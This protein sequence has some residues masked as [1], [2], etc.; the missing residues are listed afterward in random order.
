MV[1]RLRCNRFLPPPPP[2]PMGG[3]AGVSAAPPHGP[4]IKAGSDLSM[5]DAGE[6]SER[7]DDDLPV[8]PAQAPVPDM[9]ITVNS[10][11]TKLVPVIC[12]M[13]I[14]QLPPGYEDT[15]HRD[16]QYL[17][18][19]CMSFTVPAHAVLQSCLTSVADALV[20]HARASLQLHAPVAGPGGSGGPPAV[21]TEVE[22]Q[23]VLWHRHGSTT[24]PCDVLPVSLREPP[25]GGWPLMALFGPPLAHGPVLALRVSDVVGEA[26]QQ[27]R[28]GQ[29]LRCTAPHPASFALPLALLPEGTLTGTAATHGGIRSLERFIQRA[30]GKQTRGKQA[31]GNQQPNKRVRVSGPGG[32]GSGGG[33]RVTVVREGGLAEVLQAVVRGL[34]EGDT[35]DSGPSVLCL[36]CSFIGT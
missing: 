24:G 10:V 26:L 4:L 29:V 5:P 15:S 16:P 36:D 9:G 27:G 17:A 35:L 7:G 18:V 12:P 32:K 23:W 22:V 33:M 34:G 8:A 20:T 1:L 6:R 2:Q 19:L 21:D 3:H 30:S 28:A 31:R 11:D 25:F 13:G 14:G